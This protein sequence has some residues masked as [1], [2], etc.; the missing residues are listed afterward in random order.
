MQ[1]RPSGIPAIFVE[2]NRL[3]MILIGLS[4]STPS[5]NVQLSTQEKINFRF[6]QKLIEKGANIDI[7]RQTVNLT[8][9]DSPSRMQRKKLGPE[10]IHVQQYDINTGMEDVS[11]E[12]VELIHNT[13]VDNVRES[14]FDITD[15]EVKVK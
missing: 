3:V 8:V 10:V 13:V 4:G 2:D 14:E 5:R 1:K 9:E 6:N 7:E 12:L 11:Q 15:T